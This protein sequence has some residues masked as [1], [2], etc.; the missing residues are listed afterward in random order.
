VERALA[1]CFEA[2]TD[3]TLLQRAML[4]L[5]PAGDR[6]VEFATCLYHL[7]LARLF[8]DTSRV[9][10]ARRIAL[11][12]EAY[13]HPELASELVGGDPGL[14]TLWK[15]LIPYLDEFFEAQ[16]QEEEAR[17]KLETA[18]AARAVP[19]P[20]PPLSDPAVPAVPAPPPSAPSMFV[21]E[22]PLLTSTETR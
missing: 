6:R 10:F 11:V 13:N 16:E 3:A 9:E 15:E 2:R 1:A 5:T 8:V 18:P 12:H 7:E 22:A 19:P 21:S 4:D 14:Q 20:P 17:K